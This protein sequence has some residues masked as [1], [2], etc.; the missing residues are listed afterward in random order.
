[1]S[2]YI[3]KRNAHWWLLSVNG[4]Q[5]YFQHNESKQFYEVMHNCGLRVCVLPEFSIKYNANHVCIVIIYGIIL[6]RKGE[7]VRKKRKKR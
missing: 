1:M 5:K 6:N 4:M 7:R 2:T 3:I